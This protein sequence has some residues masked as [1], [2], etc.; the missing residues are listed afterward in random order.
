MRETRRWFL[1]TL[2]AAA[3]CSAAPCDAGFAQVQKKNPFPTPPPSAEQQ[4]PAEQQATKTDAER[5]KRIALQQNE[6][7]FRAGVNRLY[8]LASELKQQ[9]DTTPTTQ[10]FS[11]QM[12][13]RTEEI[14]KVAKLLKGKAK[15]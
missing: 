7:E 15:G 10:V 2:A 4:N 9:V 6:K 13:K 5:A 14:E 1:M 3:S 11:V 12:Y 8:Q